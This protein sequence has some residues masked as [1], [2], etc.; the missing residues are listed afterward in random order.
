MLFSIGIFTNFYTL[1]IFTIE[2]DRICCNQVLRECMAQIN[3][4][5]LDGEAVEDFE[6]PEE[7]PDIK[8]R[9]K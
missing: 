2:I 8:G 4:G 1:N 7:D 3:N 6:T 9:P 5:K